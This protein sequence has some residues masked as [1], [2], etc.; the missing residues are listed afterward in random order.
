MSSEGD[1]ANFLARCRVGR[2]FSL[3]SCSQ[4]C[5]WRAMFDLGSFWTSP[6]QISSVD[7][8]L[9]FCIRY[10]AH[11]TGG[12]ELWLRGLESLRLGFGSVQLWFGSLC[13]GFGSVR[14]GFLIPILHRE[15]LFRNDP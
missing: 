7:S 4:I 3:C 13:L 10:M 15:K 5:D 14:L 12:S 2:W 1:D 11:G 9:A 8:S 6:M